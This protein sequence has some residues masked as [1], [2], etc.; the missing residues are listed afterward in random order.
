MKMKRIIDCSIARAQCKNDHVAVLNIVVVRGVVKL[1]TVNV[2]SISW[3]KKD[4]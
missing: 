1:A 4:T 3:D 2:V